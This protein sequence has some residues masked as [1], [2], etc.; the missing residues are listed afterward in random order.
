MRNRRLPFASVMAPITSGPAAISSSGIRKK[1]CGASCAGHRF[2]RWRMRVRSA[3]R[4]LETLLEALDLPRRVDDVLRAGEERVALVAHLDLDRL[5]GRPDGE[6]VAA[7]DAANLRLVERGM[8]LGL[9]GT[10]LCSDAS[11]GLA[12]TRLVR[13]CLDADALPGSGFVGEADLAVG[14][15][16]ER[17]VTAHPDVRARVKGA[18]TLA[19]DDR[20]REDVLAIATLDAE[21]LSCAVSPV[22]AGRAGLLV[23]HV[24]LLGRGRVGLLG[25]A[26]ASRGRL[27]RR[28]GLSLVGLGS[29]LRL[30]G[31]LA[32]PGRLRRGIV[33][34]R[35]LRIGLV[36]CLGP[37]GL[38]RAGADLVDPHAGQVL[39]MTAGSA[40][41]HL[42]LELEDD[43]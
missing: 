39:T 13:A 32:R 6:G 20:P 15:G 14:G 19:D 16:E 31:R 30:G 38:L 29:G 23:C 27:G 25:G 36:G 4:A 24:L 10:V 7:P 2:G 40:V 26:A 12:N 22:L 3:K 21:S 11:G 37:A 35:S 17:V 5:C 9:H 8:N 41:L 43:Q 34:R 33:R 42:L 28:V 18:A 1:R